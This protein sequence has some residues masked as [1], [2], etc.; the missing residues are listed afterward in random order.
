MD[1]T[2]NKKAILSRA[3]SGGKGS[4]CYDHGIINP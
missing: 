3:I 2:V 1:R 4:K